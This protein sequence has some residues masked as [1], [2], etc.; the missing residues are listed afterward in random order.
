[1]QREGKMSS[2]V[3]IQQFV[4]NCARD[5]SEVL[6]LDVTILDENGTRISG[7]GYYKDLIGKPAPE[8]SFFRMI[9]QTGQPG[10]IHGMKKDDDQ[11][12]SCKFRQQCQELA[13]IGFPVF[14]RNKP[15]GVIGVVGFSPEQKEKMVLNSEKLIRF[16][17]HLSTLLENKMVLID[18]SSRSE[19]NIKEDI[20][21]LPKKISFESI[22]GQDS[23]MKDTIQKARRIANSI[24]TVLI[25]GESGT[26]KEVLARA[27]HGESNRSKHPFIAVNCAAIPENL[28]E[29]EL[30]GYEGGAF[31]GAKREGNLGKFELAHRGTLFLDEIG[32]MPLSLQAKLLR[33]LQDRSIDRV[34]GRRSIPIDVRV[35]AATNR[36]LEEMMRGGTFREDLYY[37]I[38]VIPL[39][40]KPLKERREDILL[41]LQFFINKFCEMLNKGPFLIDPLVERWL[42]QYDWPGNTRQLENAVEYMINMAESEVIGFKDLPDYLFQQNGLVEVNKASSLEE[43][44]SAFEKGILESYFANDSYRNNKSM[45]ANELK[46][47]VATLY[48]KLE[49]YQLI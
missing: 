22:I 19:C 29:S 5:I 4:E 12:M 9:L 15:V 3:H 34:G 2:L 25:R 14:K 48:R 37:R 10:I 43:L 20:P 31:T 38:N 49:K 42:I 21:P 40:L 11:C 35:I 26:G 30:F 41:F 36:N 45:M 28:L 18:Y 17:S 7:T 24:S 13:T 8:G 27:I 23:G 39:H 47:S 6:G 1:M 16:L 32:D 33:V 44:V 46:I